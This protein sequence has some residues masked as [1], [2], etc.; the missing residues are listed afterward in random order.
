MET[1]K[2]IESL[3][4]Q[5]IKVRVS[6]Y[7]YPILDFMGKKIKPNFLILESSI[8]QFGLDFDPKGGRTEL[9][10]TKDGID[11]LVISKCN[12]KQNFHKKTGVSS[13]LDKLNF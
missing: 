7:R 3:R 6:H 12:K 5:G 10:I 2:T 1:V 8:R 9:L 4:K 13:A 11:Y